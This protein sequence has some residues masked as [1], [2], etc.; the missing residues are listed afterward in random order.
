[1]YNYAGLYFRLWVQ[2]SFV[3]LSLLLL[4]ITIDSK[5]F[6]KQV[7]WVSIICIVLGIG[8]GLR[9]ISYIHKCD[10]QTYQGTFSE[11]YRH[12]RRDPFTTVY[13]FHNS[14]GQVDS[15]YLDTFSKKEIYNKKLVVDNQYIIYFD[16]TTKIIVG[17]EEVNS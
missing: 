8:T 16:T 3:L 7:I 12:R 11:E 2:C 4:F 5:S 10:V 6:N 13:E 1:M 15:F 9:Y 14:D 17:I